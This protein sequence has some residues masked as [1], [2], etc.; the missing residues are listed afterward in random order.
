MTNGQCATISGCAHAPACSIRAT[1]Q[2]IAVCCRENQF[3]LVSGDAMAARV[4][5][6]RSGRVRELVRVLQ[7]TAGRLGWGDRT[8]SP[9]WPGVSLWDAHTSEP[10]AKS[11]VNPGVAGCGARR[12]SSGPVSPTPIKRTRSDTGFT[13]GVTAEDRIALCAQRLKLPDVANQPIRCLAPENAVQLRAILRVPPCPL[14]GGR[15]SQHWRQ[16]ARSAISPP[17][18]CLRLFASRPIATAS[19][20]AGLHAGRISWIARIM[21]SGRREARPRR[22]VSEICACGRDEPGHDG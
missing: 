4:D 3:V 22:I 12:P 6:S 14:D 21:P 16:L 20:L 11:E 19:R 18:R 7:P 10:T 5:L 8:S 15:C 17:R 1:S 9:S 13:R 2:P